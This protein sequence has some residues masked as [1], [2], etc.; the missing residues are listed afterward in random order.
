MRGYVACT[1][2]CVETLGWARG[3]LWV[4]VMLL[5]SAACVR[6]VGAQEPAFAVATIR[7]SAAA[8]QFEHDGRTETAPGTLRM[9]DV[10]VA[11]CIKWA[12]GVQDSQIAGPAWM[13]QDHFDITAKADGPAEDAQMKVM[14]QALLAERFKLA[15]HRQE[16]ELKSFAM[17]VA[18]GGSKLKAAEVSDGKSVMQNSA[19]GTVAKST[20]MKEFG[21]MLSGPLQTPVVDMTG[22]KGKYDFTLDFTS[23]LPEDMKTMRPDAATVIMSAL[24]GE[25]GLKLEAQ[26]EMVE[27]M[28]VDHVERPS[29]N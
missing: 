12:Y 16:K 13:Q 27:V 19:N 21:D 15:F 26:K 24:K 18:K 11:T 8:V 7:P 9:R 23:Y 28:M 20:T 29:E 1:R 10:T 2:S 22:L 14:M 4:G 25:L 3:G 5:M 17:T 6:G